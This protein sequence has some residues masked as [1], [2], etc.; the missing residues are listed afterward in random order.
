MP[1]VDSLYHV[2][3][4]LVGRAIPVPV[5]GDKWVMIVDEIILFSTIVGALI[6]LGSMAYLEF[7]KGRPATT[8]MRIVQSLVVS[9]LALGIVG[10]IGVSIGLSE[11]GLKPGTACDGI[12]V[13]LVATIWSEHMWTL[14][15]A[16]ST[17]MI[18][19]YPLHAITLWLEKRWAWLLLLVW[20]CSFGLSVMGYEIY[21][22]KPSGGICYYP[23]GLFSEL[24]QFIP[25]AIVFIAISILY[26]RLYVFLRRP[27]KIRSPYSDSPTGTYSNHRRSSPFGLESF[28]RKSRGLSFLRVKRRSREEEEGQPTAPLEEIP[29]WERVDLPV[30]QIDGQK[31][32]GPSTNFSPTRGRR[33][34]PR[35]GLFS[36]TPQTSIPRP[37]G[38]LSSDDGPAPVDY[39]SPSEVASPNRE[40]WPDGSPFGQPRIRVE[41]DIRRGSAAT[42]SSAPSRLLETPTVPTARNSVS[43]RPSISDS[44]YNDELITP[45]PTEPKPSLDTQAEEVKSDTEDEQLDL[46]NV[47]KVTAPPRSQED[48]FAP[49]QGESIVFVEESMA[50]YLN[51]KTSLL[52][53]W[54]PLGYVMLFSVSLV[55]IIYDIAGTPPKPLRAVSRWFIFSQGILDAIIYGLVEWHTKRMVRRKVRRDAMSPTTS[56]S[57]Q[58]QDGS[59][60][61]VRASF[62]PRS[63]S[64]NSPRL[65][66]DAS[67][68]S[69]GTAR[70][71]AIEMSQTRRG[72]QPITTMTGSGDSRTS[73]IR[74]RQDMERSIL[75]ELVPEYVEDRRPS[76]PEPKTPKPD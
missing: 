47:L 62:I 11:G 17:Y 13:V 6:I 3:A 43:V 70:A 60:S 35:T 28:K 61:W 23:T 15:L 31:Y 40:S 26:A 57:G 72:S 10:A 39:V 41:Q 74:P 20:V 55:R 14:L 29:P 64:P 32:G 24:M 9:D 7:A 51:R 71:A 38:S 69:Q 5:E 68:L 25:R 46:M 44:A 45:V 59:G 56:P 12:G 49:R 48:P 18:L 66:S 76:I 2:G 53:L 30:F 54:F 52:M 73:T 34:R 50:S 21:G 1:V 22:Y 67:R 75:Q 58:R 8:R 27:D 36:S 37:F 63:R 33:K 42:T 4:S 19:I 65:G 16:L